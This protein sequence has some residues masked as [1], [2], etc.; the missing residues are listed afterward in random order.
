M[1]KRPPTKLTRREI[2]LILAGLVLLLV[3]AGVQMLP[4]T[5]PLVQ[6]SGLEWTA[7]AASPALQQQPNGFDVSRA[8]IPREEI[9]YGGPPRDGIP[10]IDN[11]S[12][13][14]VDSVDY[15]REDDL[16]VSVKSGNEVKAYPLRILVWHEIVNDEVGDVPLVVTYCPLCGTA[17]VFERNID[18]RVLTFGV[19]GLLYQ[20]DVLM[21]DQQTESLWSQLA[22]EAVAGPMVNTQLDWVV[23]E[24]LTWSAWKRENPGGLVLSTDTGYSR[25]YATMPYGGYEGSPRTMFPVPKYN[26]ELANKTWVLGVVIDGDAK[27]YPV[28]ELPSEE[29]IE[30]IVGGSNILVRYNATEQRPAVFDVNRE[31]EIP[32]VK[33]YWFAWQAF[34]PETDLW[35]GVQNKAEP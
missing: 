21:Y 34:Y 22:M 14:P 10:S 23:S 30:D 1:N 17:M 7:G 20:S 35:R 2:G 29:P 6:H 19:S 18:G 8:T 26:E 15:L 33:A 3:A 24:H 4:A 32:F 5:R 27:A 31:V 16:L 13:L 25:N 12:F 28:E 9:R 11:P